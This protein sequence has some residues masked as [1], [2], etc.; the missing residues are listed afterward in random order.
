M[1]KHGEATDRTILVT[2][3]AGEICGHDRATGAL[4]WKYEVAFKVFGINGTLGG[5]VDLAIQRGRVYA[6]TVDRIVCLDYATGALVGEVKLAKMGSRPTLLVD[7]DFLYVASR[8]WLECF[9]LDGTSVWRH[10]RQST[11][12]DGLALGLPGNIR[13]GDEVGR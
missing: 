12:S 7:D 11:A 9:T 2:A 4:R 3:G 5:A 10:E 13:Q 8:H 6:L 1:N